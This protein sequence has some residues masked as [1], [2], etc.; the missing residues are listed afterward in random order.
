MLVRKRTPSQMKSNP[1]PSGLAGERGNLRVGL[2]LVALTPVGGSHTS[3]QGLLPLEASHM[4]FPLPAG[5]LAGWAMIVPPAPRFLLPLLDGCTE[6]VTALWLSACLQYGNDD[7]MDLWEENDSG[8]P[9][10]NM[11]PRAVRI[12][13]VALVQRKSNHL[14]SRRAGKGFIPGLC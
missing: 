8:S 9:G 2:N 13:W 3:L 6:Q 1:D 7:S 12:A 11:A 14:C 5:V 10:F 4:G